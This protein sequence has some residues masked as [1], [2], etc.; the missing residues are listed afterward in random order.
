MLNQMY[1]PVGNLLQ[2]LVTVPMVDYCHP[3]S[4]RSSP[5][6]NAHMEDPEKRSSLLIEE[7]LPT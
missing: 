6:C 3:T 1:R 2:T 5:H 7:T 4:P